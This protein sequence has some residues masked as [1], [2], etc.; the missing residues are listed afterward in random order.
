M[1][2]TNIKAVI[3]DLGG[4]LIDIDYQKTIDEFI[5]IGVENASDLYNQFDQKMLFDEYEKGKV[6]SDYFISQIAPSLMRIFK[7][8]SCPS[9]SSFALEF[10]FSLKTRRDNATSPYCSKSLGFTVQI[11]ALCAPMYSI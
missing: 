7:R 5:K 2:N 1:K 4:V 10:Q 6:S 8:I 11:V 9:V 3:F